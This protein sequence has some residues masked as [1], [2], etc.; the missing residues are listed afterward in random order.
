M[1]KWFKWCIS[2]LPSVSDWLNARGYPCAKGYNSSASQR[3]SGEQVT[4]CSGHPRVHFR[5]DT[6]F[7]RQ[8]WHSWTELTELWTAAGLILSPPDRTDTVGLR[9]AVGLIL[10]PSD[11]TDTAG[12]RTAVGLIL[13]PPDGTDT[14]GLRTAVGL[15]L[16]PPDRTDTAGLTARLNW[17]QL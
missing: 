6:V 11:R 17:G 9:T 16:S 5:S 7:I 4:L 8:D 2:D 12:L 3:L 13:S 1:Y 10:S 15:I 14:A